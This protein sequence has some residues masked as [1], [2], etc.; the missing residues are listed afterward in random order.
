[1]ARVVVPAGLGGAVEGEL[2]DERRGCQRR[3][4]GEEATSGQACFRHD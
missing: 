2:A 1:M 3:R 4:G